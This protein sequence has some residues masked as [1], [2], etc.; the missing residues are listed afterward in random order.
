M[1]LVKKYSSELVRNYL[2]VR[3]QDSSVYDNVLLSCMGEP[4]NSSGNQKADS[5]KLDVVLSAIEIN[6]HMS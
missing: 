1:V 3:H 4:T 6:R 5:E 2:R